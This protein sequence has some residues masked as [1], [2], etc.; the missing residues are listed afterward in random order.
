MRLNVDALNDL[1]ILKSGQSTPTV[2]LTTPLATFIVTSTGDSGTG[3]LRQAIFDAN[4]TVGLDSIVFNIPGTGPHT[5]TPTSPLPTITDAVTIDGTTQ[6]G[7]TGSPIIELDGSMAGYLINGLEVT[8]GNSVVRGLVINRFEEDG[9]R[10]TNNGRNMIEGNYI[11]TDITGTV[12]YPTRSG[13]GVII[14]S[15]RSRG[16]IVVLDGHQYTILWFWRLIPGACAKR[17][18]SA[19]S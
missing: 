11:G 18:N 2:V 17:Q 7:F 8:A 1:V 19:G 12:R 16:H 10:L 9:I 13:A 15:N 4:A 3:S 6:P 5:I 14:I